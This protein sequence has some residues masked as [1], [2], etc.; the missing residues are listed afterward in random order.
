MQNLHHGPLRRGRHFPEYPPHV[1][2]PSPRPLT[3]LSQW[4]PRGGMIDSR[5]A[6]LGR[7][8]RAFAPLARVGAAGRGGACRGSF[9]WL[10]AAILAAPQR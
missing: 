1:P 8:C 6:G 10:S 4:E 5:R 2:S 7:G 9:L 3:A